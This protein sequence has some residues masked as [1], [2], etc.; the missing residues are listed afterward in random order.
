LEPHTSALVASGPRGQSKNNPLADSTLSAVVA[1][2]TFRSELAIE[3]SSQTGYWIYYSTCLAC[4]PARDLLLKRLVSDSHAA[5]IVDP[6][7][8]KL[9][10]VQPVLLPDNGYR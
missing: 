6:K 2:S 3:H 4:S 7:Q 1:R 9:V 5:G 8:K 10:K